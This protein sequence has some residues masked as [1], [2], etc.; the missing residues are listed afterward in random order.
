M[1]QLAKTPRGA[2]AAGGDVPNGP[3]TPLPDTIVR[4]LKRLVRRA[5]MVAA[6]RG[7]CAVAAVAAGS[8]MAAMAVDAGI[9]LFVAWPR[10]ALSLSALGLT[11]LAAVLF[12]IR[13]LVR[14]F[15]LA[16]VARAIE[17]RH[18]ELQER[19][20]SAI[21]LLTSPDSPQLRGSAALIAALTEE[22][23]QDASLVQA[24][25]EVTLRAA[26]PYVL[27]AVIAAGLL[28]AAFVLWPRQAGQAWQRV[29]APY[30]DLPSVFA[31][32]L[33]VVPGDTVIAAGEPLTVEVEVANKAVAKAQFRRFAGE[34]DAVTE[35]TPLPS[36]F[37]D[38]PR[39]AI[40]PPPAAESFRYRIYAGDAWSQYY[41]VTVVPR[42]VIERLDVL[43]EYPS[44]T[45]RSGQLEQNVNGDLRALVGTR[46]TLTAAT[47]TPV[48]AA[49]LLINDEPVAE[50]QRTPDGATCRFQFTMNK[51]LG[52]V[53]SI[54]LTRALG[55]KTF[56]GLSESHKI[57]P[58]TDGRPLVKITSPEATAMQMK[59]DDK[60]PI[61]FAAGDD[62]GLASAELLVD[63]DGRRQLPTA[64]PIDDANRAKALVSQTLLDL[65][66]LNSHG[67]GVI[68][69]RIRVTDNLPAEFEGPQ[70][71]L[72][73]LHTIRMDA[74]A[75]SYG[76]QVVMAEEL[77][78]R[79]SL[80]LA[81]R[82]LQEAKKD[83][84]PLRK[85]FKLSDAN[86]APAATAA[87]VA[88]VNAERIDRVVKHTEAADAAIRELLPRLTGGDFTPI[89]E[90]L[91]AV[92]DN[93]IAR[94]GNL[95]AQ[96]KL[97]EDARQRGELADEADFQIDRGITVIS[98]MLK[99][100][101]VLAQ[102]MQRAQELADLAEK[103]QEL[104]E[105]M[106]MM[107][108][109]PSDDEA[110][111]QP[112]TQPETQ[113]ASGPATAPASQPADTTAKRNLMP[114]Q[115]WQKQEAQ[116]A[117]RLGELMKQSPKAMQQ[118]LGRG[119]AK[120]KDLAAE[121]RKLAGLQ[122]SVAELTNR[123]IPIAEQD[124]A[125]KTLAEEQ[126]ALGKRLAADAVTS[127]PAT[128]A[129]AAPEDLRTGK[130]EAALK[131]MKES[132][133]SMA[134]QAQKLNR[135]V[136]GAQLARQAESIAQQ[137]RS[138]S[139][140]AA[141]A[142]RENL[143][144]QKSAQTAAQQSAQ[145]SQESQ[146]AAAKIQGALAD[147]Q[148]RQQKLAA[149]AEALEK[150]VAE[151]AA[152]PNARGSKPAEPMRTAAGSMTA[153]KLPQAAAP[154]KQAAQLAEQLARQLATDQA[155]AK[156]DRFDPE[157][158]A[159]AARA[160]E[161]RKAS[162]TAAA[163]AAGAQKTANDAAAK[164]A[165]AAAKA[166]AAKD[167]AERLAVAATQPAAGAEPPAPAAVE[168]ARKAAEEAR[169]EAAAAQGS[170]DALKANAD[171][172]RQAAA[173]AAKAQAD[174]GKTAADAQKKKDDFAKAAVE[175][176]KLADQAAE[177]AAA[178]KKIDAEVGDLV[179]GPAAKVTQAA[180]AAKQAQ[181]EQAQHTKSAEAAME[182]LAQLA[183][184]QQ[185]VQKQFADLAKAAEKAT[186]EAQ[187]AVKK[188]SPAAAME[189]ARAALSSKQVPGATQNA[190]QAAKT[191]Q[192]L[193]QALRAADA[194]TSDAAQ[195]AAK[196]AQAAAVLADARTAAQEAHNAREAAR[197][198]ATVAA[199]TQTAKATDAPAKAL[200]AKEASDKAAKSA[201]VAAAAARAATEAAKSAATAKPP[202]D[203]QA[204]QAQQAAQTAAKAVEAAQAAAEQAQVA[205][206][207]ADKAERDARDAQ[208][209]A[210]AAEKPAAKAKAG[211]AQKAATAAGKQA[212]QAQQAAAA[213][214]RHA[215]SAQDAAA[216]MAERLA[217][218][219]N[220][221][222]AANAGKLA[223]A[224]RQQE[225][226]RKRVESAATA[227]A[228]AGETLKNE[229]LA[230]LRAEQNKI[231]K[232]AA[233]LSDKVK[234][235]APQED[236]IDTQAA[237]SAVD[238]AVQVESGLTPQAVQTA[239]A[240]A[241]D[242]TELAQRLGAEVE[243]PPATTQPALPAAANRIKGST[244][245][246]PDQV[247]A[248]MDEDALE[249]K[250]EEMTT[251]AGQLAQRQ[252]LVA[253]QLKALAEN[254]PLEMI[255]P[256]QDRVSRDTTSLADN[257]D[258]LRL[259]ADDLIPDKAARQDANQAAA[260]VETAATAQRQSAA[261]IAAAAP[262][263][264]E[265]LQRT[266]GTAL[267]QT[268]ESLERLGQRMAELASKYPKDANEED[269]SN[270][271]SAFE[272]AKRAARK[273]EMRDI[274]L[275]RKLL[276]EL[277]KQSSQMLASMG[278]PVPSEQKQQM[279]PG[280]ATARTAMG[281][282]PAE[283]LADELRAAG[284]KP[285]DWGMLPGELRDEIL[286]SSGN[287]G[288]E[289][290][291]MLIKRYLEE[292]AK[293]GGKK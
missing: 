278:M 24:R 65:A 142:T 230:L 220:N 169:N 135:Q 5:R 198:A 192:E 206:A 63:V 136:A 236:R 109:Q 15:T 62:F 116:V 90:R 281:Q 172:A 72:S 155:A 99:E 210:A 222:R 160:A 228:K 173:N 75:F 150:A 259:F 255:P 20:S 80:E 47:N 123:I 287:E 203:P 262:Q 239:E 25:R 191:A 268:A 37:S 179:A 82:E 17:S 105:E 35:M 139:D 200:A 247:A 177:L 285:S 70:E 163:T 8:L 7:L 132:Q 242:L 227:R 77:A 14:T 292:L 194:A 276:E 235:L 10:W 174:A 26:R 283:L 291:R 215:Q 271:Q 114:P 89:A 252:Q 140:Q 108:P 213:A 245:Q 197:Q 102:M 204:P 78:V 225:E 45:G 133:E 196:N 6:I 282:V 60:L 110:T 66:A 257:I 48:T 49:Q 87:V 29:V 39:F 289:E 106:R 131:A 50:A 208:Q 141:A 55:G 238:A 83:S 91:A 241:R 124:R 97:A 22:A 154:A 156:P 143:A 153:E 46:L 176:K 277:S 93:H 58:V 101:T 217:A 40:T 253:R 71:A 232:E 122:V 261:A 1:M 234:S 112:T 88:G 56:T 57:E 13:P 185:D 275:A 218:N 94:A 73:D 68:T 38:W 120:T 290:Y 111:S 27:A 274:E 74:H 9:T 151:N 3:S 36:K 2:L 258:L 67:A 195:A 193:A 98:D 103:Q 273:P 162:E 23:T 16:G 286:Q 100:L 207:T 92:A 51:R 237:R 54:K 243:A 256:K 223:E 165:P 184:P 178:Q 104:A 269:T 53:W 186:P 250:R 263:A 293:R 205:Q 61:F 18:P 181:A 188:S 4:S 180:A 95:T 117:K 19:I 264:A 21:E 171:N 147:L 121:A 31:Y 138:I 42:P 240:A 28:A 202:A 279:P 146:Q 79:E 170:A 284:I 231:S 144:S 126:A 246:T 161:A 221:Q 129:A 43:Y 251:Q 219:E 190:A 76:R 158:K 96:I 212:S 125:I 149:A 148:Q 12:L 214:Q 115:E 189:Q 272:A 267:G 33:T 30:K 224:A 32:Q 152:T 211:E 81:L 128:Q 137:Q 265:P 270:L 175:A 86:E 59:P 201:D 209:A 119:G 44:Y 187:Q 229:Q 159:A 183:K 34:Q 233:R 249:A 216:A 107:L 248:E 134:Q 85:V 168:A 11:L 199:N 254:R 182:R 166:K 260:M 84:S 118:A 52:G 69:F 266:A 41:T 280:K 167:A 244:R 64:L 288:P 145:A 164:A 113:P 130:S 226:L 157:I 127:Q